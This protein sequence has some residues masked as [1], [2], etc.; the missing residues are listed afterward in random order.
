M[1]DGASSHSSHSCTPSLFRPIRPTLC[2]TNSMPQKGIVSCLFPDANAILKCLGTA[3]ALGPSLTTEYTP[4][5]RGTPAKR[6]VAQPP[7]T[8]TFSFKPLATPNMNA[9][10]TALFVCKKAVED[11]LH[12]LVCIPGKGTASAGDS[13]LQGKGVFEF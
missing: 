13:S 1:W 3:P 2:N 10:A 12:I 4:C 9:P 8:G 7:L 6:L 11:M 5:E